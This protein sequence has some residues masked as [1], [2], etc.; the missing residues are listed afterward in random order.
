MSYVYEIEFAGKNCVSKITPDPNGF[1]VNSIKHLREE[2]T[3]PKISSRNL[4][5]VYLLTYSMSTGLPLYQ[6]LKRTLQEKK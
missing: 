4:M 5:R 1:T 6:N 3:I 2:I